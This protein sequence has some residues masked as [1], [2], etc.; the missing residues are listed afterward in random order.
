MT[1]P[2]QQTETG[3]IARLVKM[4]RALLRQAASARQARVKARLR[5]QIEDA[6]IERGEG[7]ATLIGRRPLVQR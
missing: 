2:R 3:G 5:Q 7:V 4:P 6:D 1:D